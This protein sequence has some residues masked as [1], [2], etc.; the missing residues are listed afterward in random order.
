MDLAV[1]LPK[2]S[3]IAVKDVLLRRGATAEFSPAFQGRDRGRK[4]IKSR[5]RRLS[6]CFSRR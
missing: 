2:K 5:Q 3:I 6:E 1:A 4:P